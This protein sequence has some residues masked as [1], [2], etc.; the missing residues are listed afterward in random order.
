MGELATTTPKKGR[1]SLFTAEIRERILQAVRGGNYDY[2]AAQSAGVSKYTFELWKKRAKREPESEYGVFIREVTKATN[3]AET[4]IV[5]GVV[6]AGLADPKQWQW[7]LE[8]KCPERWGRDTYQ[9]RQIEKEL[10]AL[11]A[12]LNM[13]MGGK[14]S[15]EDTKAKKETE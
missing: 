9:I 13:V 10:N 14:F 1:P 15:T 7:W 8:R 11:K 6:A 12:Q 3:D 2:I 4:K 5:S